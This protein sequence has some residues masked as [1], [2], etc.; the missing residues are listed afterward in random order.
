[1]KKKLSLGTVQFGLDYGISN[2]RGK[3]PEH[4]VTKILDFASE[5]GIRMLDTATAYGESE[6]VI[7]NYIKSHDVSFDIVSKVSSETEGDLCTQLDESILRLSSAPNY[8]YLLH[9]YQD[10]MK[11]P[12]LLDCL[13][14]YRKNGRIKKIGFTLY[15]P[16]ELETLLNNNVAFDLLQI[17]YN[18]FDRRF[19]YLFPEL[20]K[21]HIEIHVRSIFLQGLVFKEPYALSDFFT[22]VIEKLDRLQQL[23]KN[24]NHSVCE[25]CLKFVLKNDSIDYAVVGIDSLTQLKEIVASAS[26]FCP[27]PTM[28]ALDELVCDD[29]KILIPSKWKQ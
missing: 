15:Y 14:E 10:Y 27:S 19:E 6:A 8:G 2:E 13:A 17:P 11:N 4:E 1:M 3:I 5:H 26:G 7:G 22:P 20:K 9:S 21:R 18:V 24:C 16:K 23:A 29:E 28:D 12:E 25:I